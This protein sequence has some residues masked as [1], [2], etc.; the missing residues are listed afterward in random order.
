MTWSLEKHHNG[1]STR[2]DVRRLELVLNFVMITKF[3]Y[4]FES[5]EYFFLQ[6]HEGRHQ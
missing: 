5:I 6:N 1:K 3:I 4:N 2:Y